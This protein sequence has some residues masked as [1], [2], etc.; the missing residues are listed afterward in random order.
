M[1][2]TSI[3]FVGMTHLGLISS[4]CSATKSKNI[5]C[6][7]NSV[8]LIEKL[9]KGFF[10]IE[11]PG[12]SSTYN[13]I[14]QNITFSSDFSEINKC[15]IVYIS[16]DIAT[17]NKGNSN[18]EEI[19]KYLNTISKIVSKE[20]IVVI[21][22]QVPPGFTRKY[23]KKFNYLFYQVET[24]V[25]G[26]AINRSL[27]PE[28]YIVGCSDKNN[29]PKKYHDYLKSYNCPIFFMRYE[30]AELTKISINLFL[31]SSVTLTNFL[32]E[33]CELINAD[34]NEISPTL[35]LDKRIG[36]FAYINPGLGISGGNL[37][38]DL[39]SITNLAKSLKLSPKLVET[40]IDG[41]KKRKNWTF[42]IISNFYNKHL[43]KVKKK[44]L[45]CGL[46]Y[47][48]NTHSIKNSPSILFLQKIKKYLNFD[49]CVY[50]PLINNLPSSYKNITFMENLCV[51]D[52]DILIIMNTSNDF[53]KINSQNLIG[54]ELVIDPF[55]VIESNRVRNNGYFTLGS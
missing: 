41:S 27:Y 28:R 50:D 24:L 3:A 16:V 31:S 42:N 46:S 49:I 48:P 17:D 36:K 53:K 38:R 14:K 13:K 9:K 22:S 51:K 25:F 34:F 15:S 47:K 21:L 39:I 45:L 6:I 5:L 20:T 44:I 30:S 26:E 10:P 12:L 40:W 32:S 4:I 8:Q 43:N 18:L 33:I 23:I 29:I 54:L 7:D 11:E 55:R 19:E 52:F 2:K 35:R 1:L 37:E